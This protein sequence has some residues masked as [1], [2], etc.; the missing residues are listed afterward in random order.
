[1]G[2]DHHAQGV[3]E[4]RFAGTRFARQ[5]DGLL[6]QHR[7]RQESLPIFVAE[8]AEQ[9]LVVGRQGRFD[10]LAL[11]RIEPKR[12][13]A[14]RFIEGAESENLIEGHHVGAW[15]T[16]SYR[17]VFDDGRNHDLDA[18]AGR[19]RRAQHGVFDVDGLARI[20]GD[21]LREFFAPGAGYGRHFMHRPQPFTFGQHFARHVD[22]DFVVRRIVKEPPKRFQVNFQ[23]ALLARHGVTFKS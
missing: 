20:V 18:L 7:L 10:S 5:D 12:L 19:Q 14:P 17:N 15:P 4:R 2:R 8:Q 13:F 6:P 21:K 1:M 9:G 3:A 16:D 22:D 23:S 11:G